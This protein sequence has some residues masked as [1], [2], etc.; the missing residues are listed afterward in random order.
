M[1][2]D[3][4][5]STHRRQRAGKSSEATCDHLCSVGFYSQGREMDSWAP[6]LKALLREAWKRQEGWSLLLRAVGRAVG[7]EVC[8]GPP[9]DSYEK[10]QRR[11]LIS[12]F[13]DYSI[14]FLCV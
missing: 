6:T 1:G 5:L 8:L 7:G 9:G 12:G 3:L 4:N 10:V 11:V 2:P 14:N 13:V